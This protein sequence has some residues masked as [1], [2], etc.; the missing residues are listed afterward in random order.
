MY[1][2]TIS[3]LSYPVLAACAILPEKEAAGTN[4]TSRPGSRPTARKREKRSY[5]P[6]L[7]LDVLCILGRRGV[8]SYDEHLI[9]VF[10]PWHE[11]QEIFIQIPFSFLFHEAHYLLS[12]VNINLLPPQC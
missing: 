9:L 3:R 2:I 10:P 4:S 5:N 11:M 1:F 12:L 8:F 6:A 7:L